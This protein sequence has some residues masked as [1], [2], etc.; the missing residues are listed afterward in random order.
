ML[1]RVHRS[2]GSAVG[3]PSSQ[4]R[5]VGLDQE[6]MRY[7]E[8]GPVL[9]RL[10]VGYERFHRRSFVNYQLNRAHAL[11]FAERDE[12]RHAATMIHSQGDCVTVFEAR[13]GGRG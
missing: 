4:A 11:G 12:L 5:S 7:Q 1:R 6:S 8:S 3:T 2:L 10:P 9:A 13:S